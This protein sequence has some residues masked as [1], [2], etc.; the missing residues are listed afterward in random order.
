[1]NRKFICVI[2]VLLA[3]LPLMAQKEYI[4][5]SVGADFTDAYGGKVEYGQKI[6]NWLEVGLSLGVYNSLP[7]TSESITF[8]V[9]P[10]NNLT[11]FDVD[12]KYYQMD[13]KLSASLMLNGNVDAIKLFRPESKHGL[14][15]GIG[16]GMS[17]YHRMS[18]VFNRSETGKIS[19]MHHQMSFGF[20]F[21]LLAMYEY[22][23]TR[24]VSIGVF[25]EAM[26]V[27]E[28]TTFGVSVKRR[29]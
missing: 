19:T 2:L 18:N 28:I 21:A 11:Y 3:S 13:G 29:F 9:D 16:I 20:D 10:V 24:K 6:F 12:E 17:S 26:N 8:G 4:R 22:D 15:V 27:S 1:M 25:G 7:L 5:L 14:K 23:I